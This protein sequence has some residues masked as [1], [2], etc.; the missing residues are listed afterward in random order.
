MIIGIPIYEK[1]DLLDVAAPYEIFNW[2]S[3][4]APALK[5][6]VYLIAAEPG[7]IKTR[8]GLANETAQSIPRCFQVGCPVGAGRR[9][10]RAQ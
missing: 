8:D 9:S 10:V 5:A 3:Q 2:M 1:V 4:L 6:E 7:L